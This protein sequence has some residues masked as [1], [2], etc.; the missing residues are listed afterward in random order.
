M[1]YV[2]IFS[3]CCLTARALYLPL[4]YSPAVGRGSG[5]SFASSG[6]D[7]I[8][9]VRVWEISG[10][11]IRGL[12]LKYDYTW[13]PVFGQS[14]NE[15]QEM[16]LFDDE[17]IVQISGKY[18]PGN[19]VYQLMFV[20]NRGRFLIAG[21]PIGTSFNFYPNHRQGELRLISGR[22]DSNGITS[23]AALWAT[24]YPVAPN[25][26]PSRNESMLALS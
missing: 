4:D 11:Y 12:Q 13:T 7:R 17:A 20:T 14:L 1:I 19:Y 10:S 5:N 22:S 3:L 25:V 16:L 23:I 9:G 15:Q 18:N 24:A 8:T 26:P 21:Q 6:E 2:L